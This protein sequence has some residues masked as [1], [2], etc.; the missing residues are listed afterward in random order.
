MDR[1]GPCRANSRPFPARAG[2][3]HL[4]TEKLRCRSALT[5][6][7]HKD[8]VQRGVEGPGW[9]RT[10]SGIQLFGAPCTCPVWPLDS[11]HPPQLRHTP[12]SFKQAADVG[13]PEVSFMC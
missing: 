7:L 4:L 3:N 1:E 11:A 12:R 6:F 9:T 13:A 5:C 8:E 10:Q 2:V